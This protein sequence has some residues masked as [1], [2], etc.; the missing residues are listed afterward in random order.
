LNG[1]RTREAVR[2][3]LLW[4][5]NQGKY[6]VEA[7]EIF[8][9]LRKGDVGQKPFRVLTAAGKPIWETKNPAQKNPGWKPFAAA[10][11]TMNKALFHVQRSDAAQLRRWDKVSLAQRHNNQELT[12]SAITR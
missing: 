7:G 6:E 12:H 11:G 8:D 5:A 3:L 1:L 2:E 4:Y 9:I 10:V